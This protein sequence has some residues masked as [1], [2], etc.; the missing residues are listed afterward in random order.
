MSERI[1][2]RVFL[3][4]AAMNLF[5]SMVFYLLLTTMAVFAVDRFAASDSLAGFTST[6]FILGAVF[7]RFVATPLMRAWGRKRMVAAGALLSVVLVALYPVL[8]DIW[9]LI[10][11]RMLHGFCFGL[12]NMLLTSGVLERAPR[13]HRAQAAGYLGLPPTVSTALAPLIG[14]TM[15]A[16]WG[17]SGV[18]VASAVMTV[19]AAIPALLITLPSGRRDRVDRSSTASHAHPAVPLPKTQLLV[20]SSVLFLAGF[21]YAGVMAYLIP[22]AEG[23]GA[24][25]SV[26][27][28]F[29]LY[30]AVALVG[31][32]FVGKIQDTRGDN[33]VMYPMLVSFALSLT[34]LGFASSGLVI[35]LA[36]ILMGFGFG[37]MM[38]SMQAAAAKLVPD[39][40]LNTGL[41]VVYVSL[42]LGIAL[43]PLLIGVAV[44][45]L[46]FAGMYLVLAAIVVLAGVVY[47]L[48]H[49]R[50]RGQRIA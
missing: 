29:T 23:S 39:D 4:A 44:A 25:W 46:G 22:F 48:G 12:V 24:A 15:L 45:Q 17:M 47:A 42:D 3:L 49:G 21:G 50:K 9:V 27:V 28:Y 19:L 41:A 43:A 31:R 16:A 26:G 36:G 10:V 40:Q 11:I 18:F 7:S 35:S 20:L 2:D 30:A 32:L 34:M 38:P 33:A 5:T 14:V 1:I 8:T 37:M 13:G 6:A